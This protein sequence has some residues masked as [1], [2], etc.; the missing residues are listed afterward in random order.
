M[1][2]YAQRDSQRVDY[3]LRIALATEE[4]IRGGE[5]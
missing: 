2:P 4:M 3:P 5:A 1:H